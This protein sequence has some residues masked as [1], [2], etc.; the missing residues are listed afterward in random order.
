MAKSESGLAMTEFIPE[1]FESKVTTMTPCMF[2]KNKQ[3]WTT[4][5]KWNN[6]TRM[7]FETTWVLN[8]RT[9]LK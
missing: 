5:V 6:G 4:I 8:G 2:E 7:L 9:G 3:I 1:T